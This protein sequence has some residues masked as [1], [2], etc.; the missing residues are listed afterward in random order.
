MFV[1]S[2]FRAF[3]CAYW[4]IEN[5]SLYTPELAFIDLGR[6]ERAAAHMGFGD[7]YLLGLDLAPF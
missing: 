2:K 4:Y 5:P 3:F 6:G 1:S 7:E